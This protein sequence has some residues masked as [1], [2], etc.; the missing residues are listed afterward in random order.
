MNGEQT[1]R[2]EVALEDIMSTAQYSRIQFYSKEA[3][4]ISL[5]RRSAAQL[6]QA[7]KYLG[8]TAQS[9][10]DFINDADND[11]LPEVRHFREKLD[12]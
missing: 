10:T 9:L 7:L 6:A 1:N 3:I 8:S 2:L 5:A 4:D 11:L 12:P